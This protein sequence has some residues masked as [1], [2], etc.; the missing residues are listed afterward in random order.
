MG[1]AL[2]ASPFPVNRA[3]RV[4]IM[5][6]APLDGQRE[7][8]SSNQGRR[9]KVEARSSRTA[10]PPGADRCSPRELGHRT[11]SSTPWVA[12]THPAGRTVD[13]PFNIN[14]VSLRLTFGRY[15]LTPLE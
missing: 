9:A 5:W 10:F 2:V 8:S 1:S 14:E 3:R 12:P 7:A 15:G 6:P 13:R 4:Q 11:I